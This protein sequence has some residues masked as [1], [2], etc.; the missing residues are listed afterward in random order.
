MGIKVSRPSSRPDLVEVCCSAT[1]IENGVLKE[2]LRFSNHQK[3][4]HFE[5][6]VPKVDN[7][8]EFQ[9]K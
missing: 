2:T 7:N 5:L 4:V 3:N 1:V 8:H 9:P 6:L